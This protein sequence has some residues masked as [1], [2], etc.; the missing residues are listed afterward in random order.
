MPA[1]CRTKPRTC[2]CWLDA[3]LA[4]AGDVR[5]TG[6]AA[7]SWASRLRKQ[8]KKPQKHSRSAHVSFGAGGAATRHGPDGRNGAHGASSGLLVLAAR[9]TPSL[10]FRRLW[11]LLNIWRVL[12]IWLS[13]VLSCVQRLVNVCGVNGHVFELYRSFLQLSCH[14]CNKYEKCTKNYSKMS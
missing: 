4:C 2:L 6:D 10:L 3:R 5:R 1:F 8:M 14:Y 9:R 11:R 7:Q 12:Y 13:T